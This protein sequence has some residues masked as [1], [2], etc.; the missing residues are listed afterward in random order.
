MHIRCDGLVAFACDQCARH[1]CSAHMR[2]RPGTD[3][4]LC[5]TCWERAELADVLATLRALSRPPSKR[6]AFSLRWLGDLWRWLVA[7]WRA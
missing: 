3:A 4:D 6:R 7:R 1:V 5:P 2:K